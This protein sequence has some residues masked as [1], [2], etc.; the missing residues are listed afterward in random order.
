MLV[1]GRSSRMGR[2][3]ALLPYRGT[4]LA[5]WVARET[6]RAAGS[7]F[8][9][10]DPERYRNLGYP[11]VPD[12]WPGEGPLSGILTALRHSIAPWNLIVACDMPGL[13]SAF[14]R[15]LLEAAERNGTTTLPV[16]PSGNL[17]PL[18]GVWRRD[19]L[20]AVEAAFTAGVRKVAEALNG[21]APALYPVAEVRHFQNVNTPEDFAAHAAK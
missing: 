9:I 11:V 15:G 20:A 14:L 13:T 7:A 4:T 10:G 1:G 5:Q 2:D 8:L 3:K 12:C 6:V 19:S 17:E 21:I 18:C 16:G